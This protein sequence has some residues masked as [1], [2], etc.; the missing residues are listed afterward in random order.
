MGNKDWGDIPREKFVY[1]EVRNSAWASMRFTQLLATSVPLEVVRQ[2]I[3]TQHNVVGNQG[4]RLFLGEAYTAENEFK[5]EDF[6]MKLE[7]LKIA[8]GSK[9][10]HVRQ[11]VTYEHE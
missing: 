1:L 7:E 3:I 9:N 6:T 11:V 10:D 4:L 2:L 5:P 8:G